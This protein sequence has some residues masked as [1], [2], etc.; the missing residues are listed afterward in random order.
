MNSGTVEAP[1]GKIPAI[2]RPALAIRVT[3]KATLVTRVRGSV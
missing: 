1:V 2:R 3:E